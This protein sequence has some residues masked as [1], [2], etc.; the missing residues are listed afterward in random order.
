MVSPS[1]VQHAVSWGPAVGL[2]APQDSADE[3]TV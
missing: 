1:Q 3:V 2:V